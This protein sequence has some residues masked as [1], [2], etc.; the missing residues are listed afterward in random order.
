MDKLKL[1][2]IDV[3]KRFA[4]M[5]SEKGVSEAF[6]YFAAEDGVIMRN[7]KIYKGKA[8]IKKYYDSSGLT[9]IKLKWRPDFVDISSSGDMAY[10]Y[11]KFSFSAKDKTGKIL[12]SDGIFH[13][14][15][16]RQPD[17]KWRF[18]WD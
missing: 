1:E 11:G 6:F 4:E 18:V 3:E 5:A 13:T 9:D 12:K 14:V 7:N 10:T 8:E 17:G 2:I 16:K 15:W